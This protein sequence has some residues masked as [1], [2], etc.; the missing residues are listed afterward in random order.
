MPS[1]AAH[2]DRGEERIHAA[3][4]SSSDAAERDHLG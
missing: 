2:P 3:T 4:M 1:G